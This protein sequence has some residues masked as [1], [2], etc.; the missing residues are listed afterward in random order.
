MICYWELAL[1]YRIRRIKRDFAEKKS[2][3]TP[4]A[5]LRC[6]RDL[7]LTEVPQTFS[8]TFWS[9]IWSTY[10]IY[11]PAY[12]NDESYGFWIDVGNGHSTL[13]PSILWIIGM[14]FNVLPPR[15]FALVGIV[16]FYQEFYGTVIYLAQFLY[17]RRHHNRSALEVGLFVALSNGIWILGPL[18]GIFAAIAILQDDDFAILR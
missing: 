6:L 1:C 13:V 15:W 8:W 16:S 3:A 14:T 2:L 5:R 17:H 11:D 7:F 12:A 9:Q 18:V 4:N 10:A